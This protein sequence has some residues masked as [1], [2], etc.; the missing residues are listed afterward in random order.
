M[1]NG[2]KNKKLPTFVTVANK[3]ARVKDYNKLTSNERMVYRNQ[4]EDK[5]KSPNLMAV[6]KGADGTPVYEPTATDGGGL[7]YSIA[8]AE[9]TSSPRSKAGKN[10]LKEKRTQ[11]RQ[12]AG[13]TGNDQGKAPKTMP[14]NWW[15]TSGQGLLEGMAIP[16]SIAGV[17]IDALRGRGF[18]PKRALPEFVTGKPQASVIEGLTSRETVENYPISTALADVAL[19]I[20]TANPK[21]VV[22][23]LG[24]VGSKLGSAVGSAVSKMPKIKK[25]PRKPPPGGLDAELMQQAK[26]DEYVKSMIEKYPAQTK[27]LA[28][29]WK[30]GDPIN[31]N[32]LYKKGQ[33]DYTSNKPKF[34]PPPKFTPQK[35]ENFKP[36]EFK[37]DLEEANLKS[38]GSSKLKEQVRKDSE[39]YYKLAT[40]EE[41]YARARALDAKEGTKYEE[42]LDALKGQWND[43]RSN[44]VWE[45]SPLPFNT[46]IIPDE[47]VGYGGYSYLTKEARAK[48]YIENS[49]LDP[50]D[51]LSPRQKREMKLSGK[52]PLSKGSK[53]SIDDRMIRIIDLPAYKDHPQ[54]SYRTQSHELKH[55]Y[56]LSGG[57]LAEGGT[58]FYTKNPYFTQYSDLIHT[59]SSA[60]T[61]GKGSLK[62]VLEEVPFKDQPMTTGEYYKHPWEV[63]AYLMT[64]LKD[65]FIKHG[66][67]NSVFDKITINDLSKI[68]ELSKKA[69]PKTYQKSILN[70]VRGDKAK[71]FVKLYNESVYTAAGALGTGALLGKEKETY[72]YGGVKKKIPTSKLGQWKY[73]NQVV[74]VPGNNITMQG[75]NHPNLGVADTGEKQ[76]MMPGMNYHFKGAKEV[77]EYPMK[78]KYGG[79]PQGTV[80]EV[81]GDEIGIVQ[82]NNGFEK[83]FQTPA[84][85]PSHKEGGLDVV[86]PNDRLSMIFPKK[87][88]GVIN[89][90]L[91][92]GDDRTIAKYGKQMKAESEAAGRAGLPYS[93]PPNTN[94]M[95]KNGAKFP[96]IL[97]SKYAQMGV[98]NNQAPINLGVKKKYNPLGYFPGIDKYTSSE[99]EQRLK[100]FPAVYLEKEG[101][102][103]PIEAPRPK[104][105]MKTVN[106]EKKFGMHPSSNTEGLKAS[107][108]YA[109]EGLKKGVQ[110]KFPCSGGEQCAGGSNTASTNYKQELYDELGKDVKAKRLYGDAWRDA[111]TDK[112][113]V[114]WT[115]KD[116][117][118]QIDVT[119][120]SSTKKHLT[121]KPLADDGSVNQWPDDFFTSG[122]PDKYVGKKVMGDRENT[123]TSEASGL[124]AARKGEK[125]GGEHLSNRIGKLREH[126]YLKNPDGTPQMGRFIPHQYSGKEGGG[127]VNKA[128][129]FQDWVSKTDGWG[130][131]PGENKYTP[132]RIY[133]EAE[134]TK[135]E[136]EVEKKRELERLKNNPPKKDGWLTRGVKS[137]LGDFKKGMPKYNRYGGVH[138]AKYGTHNDCGCDK[139]KAKHGVHKGSGCGKKYAQKG[140]Y[141]PAMTGMMKARMAIDSHFGNTSAKRMTSVEPRKG[142][143]FTGEEY[144]P[145]RRRP[146]GVPKGATGTHYTTDRGTSVIPHLQDKGGQNLEFIN[147]PRESDAEA[148]HFNNDKEA[149]YF[150]EYYKNIAPMMYNEDKR[151]KNN[152]K[153]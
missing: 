18:Q 3:L 1:A 128:K 139:K 134:I 136:K 88:L 42:R 94:N 91:N 29:K 27:D 130:F 121:Y 32:E 11:Q 61:S 38:K 104:P 98:Y 106:F 14:R 70:A 12:V 120:T 80:V 50:F 129:F 65:A 114:I 119:N 124:A 37:F 102:F 83:L 78:A 113:N 126:P 108:D 35:L 36:E 13:L 69:H 28:E 16:G 133:E 59:P 105:T 55:H 46:K 140:K 64:N 92:E 153:R 43:Y 142:Y 82:G 34:T 99:Q 63:D 90:A 68:K 100:K 77:T 152:K 132:I 52:S 127:T 54:K 30:S 103:G 51:E 111:S 15:T 75:I 85:T 53:M 58:D 149:Q 26:V 143:T 47:G 86:L 110:Y 66:I 146:H 20:A 97:T 4:Y 147:I 109:Y 71:D 24:K 107:E 57:D 9:I 73:P 96:K 81:E 87:Y 62:N 101:K 148:M 7:K 41:N 19:G 138:Y 151:R 141:N 40:S 60:V 49:I 6:T 123:T 8:P 48:R 76:I 79:S 84:S 2:D 25:I 93:N 115:N 118:D 131:K 74:K 125:P 22:S 112:Y 44:I 21:G 31:F 122:I 45:K 72:R 56:T 95:A 33:K 23:G 116:Y 5:T 10:I 67:K 89:K 137:I 117:K 39:R 145:F 144:N 17:G 135:L 150:A